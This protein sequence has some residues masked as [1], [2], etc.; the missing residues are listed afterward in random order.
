M[1]FN[2]ILTTTRRY[3]L[4]GVITIIPIW[5][6]WLAIK[7]LLDFLAQVGTPFVAQISSWLNPVISESPRW[8]MHPWSQALMA[9]L[10]VLSFL[11]VLGW[12]AT[13][14]VG[15]ELIKLFDSIMSRIPMVQM[16]YGSVKKV[17]TTLQSKP[18]SIQRVVLIDFPSP[19]LKSVGFVTRTFTDEKTGGEL[20][21]VYVPTTPNPTSG[22][23]EIVPIE[24]LTP[25][26]WTVD[27][28]MTFI[29]S[30]GAVM[31]KSLTYENVPLVAPLVP[32]PGDGAGPP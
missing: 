12:I 21:A 18:D 9:V 32:P 23:L 15:R 2:T 13:K 5:I 31:P 26:A 10:L 19:E 6:T 27:E 16:I 24:Q 28:A 8:L 25:L 11:Y 14:V 30:V 4:T 7:F 29:I 22:Y 3:L 20:A 1:A 17:M